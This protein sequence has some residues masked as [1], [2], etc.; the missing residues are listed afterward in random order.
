[1]ALAAKMAKEAKDDAAVF[2]IA[3]SFKWQKIKMRKTSAW[4]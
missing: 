2:S 1:M 3:L 4:L